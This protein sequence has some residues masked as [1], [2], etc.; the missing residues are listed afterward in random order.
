MTICRLGYTRHS[1]G[2][3]VGLFPCPSSGDRVL[4]L[5]GGNPHRPHTSAPAGGKDCKPRHFGD[6]L[7]PPCLLPKNFAAT[8]LGRC[9]L[10]GGFPAPALRF[11]P[12]DEDGGFI[13]QWLAWNLKGRW[14]T[15]AGVS[16]LDSLPSLDM[17]I[18]VLAGGR[19]GPWASPFFVTLRNPSGK[20]KGLLESGTREFPA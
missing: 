16:I 11:G 15:R 13:A 20:A 6:T 14:V 2:P 18:L 5:R 3:D 9:Y 19:D 1:K 10:M 8:V 4:H 12:E 17:P 7:P